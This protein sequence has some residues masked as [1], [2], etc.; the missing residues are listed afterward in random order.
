MTN[1]QVFKLV[2][3][4]FTESDR[5]E[6]AVHSCNNWLVNCILTTTLYP[7]LARLFKTTC[8]GAMNLVVDITG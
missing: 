5:A 1:F 3:D 6:Q 8:R 7:D 4:L 2:S